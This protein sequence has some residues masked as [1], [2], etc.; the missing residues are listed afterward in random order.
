MLRSLGARLGPALIAVAGAL[1]A[2]VLMLA[3]L[4]INP[5]AGRYDD[6][7]IQRLA[8]ERIDEITPS[9]PIEPEIYALMQPSVVTVFREPPNPQGRT[10]GGLGSGVVVD[11]FGNILTAYHVVAGK[12]E[13]TVGFADGSLR[14]A[15][16]DVEEPERD[17]AVLHV[18]GL[19]AG[20][21]PATLGGGVRTGDKVMAIGSPFGLESS[22]TAGVVSNTGRS[23][24][25][26]ATGTVLTDMIQFDAAVNPG[27]SGGPLVD[28][29][30]RVVG[31]VTG[32][33]T[34]GADGGFI[35]LGFAVP[36][37]TAGGALP[38]V[39]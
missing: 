27:S 12:K 39:G 36:I 3:Y 4:Q 26:D 16:V 23:F 29:A 2:L 34:T 14:T 19:P 7:D 17:L 5:P 13:V 11:D 21:T 35:G 33:R 15:T 30:G 32:I 18:N 22:F 25:V 1:V 31:I 20:V 38:P 10:A 6:A 28:M 37:E 9:P 8:D 24:V